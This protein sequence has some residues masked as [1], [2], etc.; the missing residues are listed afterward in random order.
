MSEDNKFCKQQL[1]LR[2][3]NPQITRFACIIQKRLTTE[4][5]IDGANNNSLLFRGQRSSTS[6]EVVILRRGRKNNK[7]LHQDNHAQVCCKFCIILSFSCN[8]NYLANKKTEML[9]VLN[10]AAQ[11]LCNLRHVKKYNLKQR[12]KFH[13]FFKRHI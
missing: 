8:K 3:T 7:K 12:E 5:Q 1:K 10:Y 9:L 2:I 6:F 4:V 11:F 13:L